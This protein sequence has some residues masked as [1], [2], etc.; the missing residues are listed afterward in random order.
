MG[1]NQRTWMWAMAWSVTT[2]LAGLRGGDPRIAEALDDAE[3]GKRLL[4][5]ML[6]EGSPVLT[7]NAWD[8]VLAESKADVIA[9]WVALVSMRASELHASQV[10]RA[11]LENA[12]LRA[13]AIAIGRDEQEMRELGELAAKVR[14]GGAGDR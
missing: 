2:V 12:E 11:F 9:W 6:A 14:A 13:Y 10:C 4:L 3:Q 5:R 1:A 7:E 8:G